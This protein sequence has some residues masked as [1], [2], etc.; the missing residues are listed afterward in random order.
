MDAIGAPNGRQVLEQDGTDAATLVGVLD[1]EGHLGLGWVR[2]AVVSSNR[3]DGV[4]QLGDKRHPVA[5]VE[6]GELFEL[7]DGRSGHGGEEA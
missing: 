4:S 1:D 6:R 2:P 7:S 3:D 5:V